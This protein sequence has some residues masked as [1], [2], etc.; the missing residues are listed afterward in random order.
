[1]ELFEKRDLYADSDSDEK[2]DESDAPE[3]A[4]LHVRVDGKEGYILKDHIQPL[5]RYNESGF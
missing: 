4:F 1:V 5:T 3:K 2:Q